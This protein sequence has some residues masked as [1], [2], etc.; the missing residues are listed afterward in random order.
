[1]KYEFGNH[2]EIGYD[3]DFKTV[4]FSWVLPN[5][6]DLQKEYN[7]LFDDREHQE[8]IEDIYHGWKDREFLEYLYDEKKDMFFD[9]IMEEHKTRGTIKDIKF[10]KD[11]SGRQRLM[12]WWVP[13]EWFVKSFKNNNENIDFMIVEQNLI[14]SISDRL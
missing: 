12:C 11:D 10:V 9:E 14:E 8:L 1:M 13:P 4:T 3:P 7:E 2:F 5:L 6:S